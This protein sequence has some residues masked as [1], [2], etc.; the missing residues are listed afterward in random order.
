MDSKKRKSSDGNELVITIITI[1]GV[2]WLC[3]IRLESEKKTIITMTAVFINKGI[4]GSF[5]RVVRPALRGNVSL[6]NK[7]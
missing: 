6:N 2:N 5:P 4:Q 3:R 7:Y 1:G